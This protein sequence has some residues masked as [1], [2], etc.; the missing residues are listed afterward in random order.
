MRGVGRVW[1]GVTWGQ[2]GGRVSAEPACVGARPPL[3][4]DLA[5][6]EDA[7]H[8]LVIAPESGYGEVSRCES[9]HLIC[10]SGL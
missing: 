7:L 4:T 5:L 6:I 9:V 8:E 2:A 3:R 10:K 1:L